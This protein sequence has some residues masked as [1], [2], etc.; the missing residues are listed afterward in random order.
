MNIQNENV[1]NILKTCFREIR[2][3]GPKEVRAAAKL[4]NLDVL[5][6]FFS[7]C[8]RETFIESRSELSEL[9]SIGYVCGILF[10]F[11][12]LAVEHDK[13]EML[14]ADWLGASNPNPN[15]VLSSSLIVISNYS[16]SILK[17]V[18]SGLN[19]PARSLIRV[20]LEHCWLL[21]SILSDRELFRLYCQGRASEEARELWY[22]HFKPKKLNSHL[23]AIERRIWFD[24]NNLMAQTRE[25]LY[26]HYSRSVHIDYLTNVL[27]GFALSS[28]TEY[29]NT[30]LFGQLSK[31]S[32]IVLKDSSTVLI[33]TYSTIFGILEK[34]HKFEIAA[35]GEYF[36][37]TQAMRVP[38][39]GL[40]LLLVEYDDLQS[41]YEMF[42]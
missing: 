7:D 5:D 22:K 36:S 38:L 37:F 10:G 35:T 6:R 19:T 26:N 25:T 31:S 23:N 28:E 9:L 4:S 12:A 13:V 18:E 8:Q 34:I 27:G 30:A 16:I 33:Y 3:N 17:L 40:L 29:F 11:L 42:C 14:P 32:K 1:R 20:L 2:K 21:L 39:K 15:F 41:E 24:N